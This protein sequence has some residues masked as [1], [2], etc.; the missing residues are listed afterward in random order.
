[1]PRLPKRLHL[2]SLKSRFRKEHKK[3]TREQAIGAMRKTFSCVMPVLRDGQYVSIPEALLNDILE[4][5]QTNSARYI[6]EVRDCDDF[7]MKL[8]SDTSWT[9]K[10][11]FVGLVLDN[12]MEH[13]YNAALVHDEHGN[14][15]FVPFEPQLDKLRFL[16]R[17]HSMCQKGGFFLF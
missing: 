5:D 8:V 16:P 15:E 1:M 3:A 2:R 12:A 14:L 9:Y 7:A 17:G 6:K 13:A 4:R 11:T 10:G